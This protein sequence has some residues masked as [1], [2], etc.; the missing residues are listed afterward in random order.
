MALTLAD[1]KRLIKKYDD[2]MGIVVKGK[3]LP[4]LIKEIESAGYTVDHDKKTLTLTGKNKMKRKPTAVKAAPVEKKAPVDKSAARAKKKEMIIK[5]FLK[6]PT[7]HKEI[8]ADE[9]IKKQ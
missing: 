3:K 9:R 7:L 6:D 1:V 4:A 5:S 2:L 8:M